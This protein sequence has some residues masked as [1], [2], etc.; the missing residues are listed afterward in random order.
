MVMPSGL[1]VVPMFQRT[2]KPSGPT[3][4]CWV[5]I[6]QYLP[7]AVFFC[8]LFGA[9]SSDKHLF[10]NGP[11]V[12]RKR[13]HDLHGPVHELAAL[14]SVTDRT[15]EDISEVAAFHGSLSASLATSGAAIPLSL[16]RPPS[17]PGSVVRIRST[18]ALAIP[19]S[20]RPVQPT[21]VQEED[22][23]LMPRKK[24]NFLAIPAFVFALGALGL[25][26]FTTSTIAV[27]V[28]AVL[29]ILLAGLSIRRIRSREQGGKG[30]ALMALLLGLL[31]LLATAIAV[32]VVGFV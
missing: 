11:I 7:L 5:R 32:A 9:C 30:F 29:A 15:D 8:S 19:N 12:P 24:L 1:S 22:E 6:P 10:T 26:L 25:G 3:C 27:I 4:L 14:D 31:A 17:V 28:A 18:D 21:A 23:N 2:N 20:T 13:S 16:E